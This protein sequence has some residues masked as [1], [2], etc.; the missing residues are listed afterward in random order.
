MST[1]LIQSE[2]KVIHFNC[3]VQLPNNFQRF[4]SLFEFVAFSYRPKTSPTTAL[5]TTAHADTVTY[6]ILVKL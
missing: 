5:Q 2:L 4:F 3:C 6:E 1:L